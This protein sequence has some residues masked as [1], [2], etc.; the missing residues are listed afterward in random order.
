MKEMKDVRFGSDREELFTAYK[1]KLEAQV[2]A[3][4]IT[5]LKDYPV[6]K[7]INLLA[8]CI[9]ADAVVKLQSE[10]KKLTV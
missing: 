7:D 10:L 9:A 1:N 2:K 6:V 4:V 5:A 8:C 3:A